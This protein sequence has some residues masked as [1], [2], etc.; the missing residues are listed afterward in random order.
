V[1]PEEKLEKSPNG[2]RTVTCTSTTID[3]K[4][5][6]SGKSK[7]FTIH[8][9]DVPS[10]TD[11]CVRWASDRYLEYRANVFGYLDADTLKLNDAGLD[12][13]EDFTQLQYD[14]DFK[15]VVQLRAND[16]RIGKLVTQ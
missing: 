7:S 4:E 14:K 8:P 9:D 3:I 12:D 5:T 13:T 1:P 2:K 10:F 16:I 15:F 11:G 6:A